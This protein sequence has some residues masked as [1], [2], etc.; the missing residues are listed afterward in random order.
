MNDFLVVHKLYHELQFIAN[1]NVKLFCWE[2]SMFV[3][4]HNPVHNRTNQYSDKCEIL[5]CFSFSENHRLRIFFAT[6]SG[7][8][9]FPLLITS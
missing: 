1:Q 2:N 7:L 6:A 5:P 9:G 4:K 8:S 3:F